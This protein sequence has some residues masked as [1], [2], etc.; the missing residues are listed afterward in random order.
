M[1]DH[2][3]LARLAA[4]TPLC[5]PCTE[6]RHQ[7]CTRHTWVWTEQPDGRWAQT[8]VDCACPCTQDR[9]W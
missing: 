3:G 7:A 1:G 2:P 9:L 4:L 8:Q 6:R 5:S